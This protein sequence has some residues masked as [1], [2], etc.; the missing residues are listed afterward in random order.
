MTNPDGPRSNRGELAKALDDLVHD[1][2]RLA[3]A[4][5]MCEAWETGY[6]AR[7]L[8]DAEHIALH[9]SCDGSPALCADRAV[10]MAVEQAAPRRRV[11]R[12]GIT[13]TP[14]A[15]Q[16]LLDLVERRARFHEESWPLDRR[17]QPRTPPPVL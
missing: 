4:L 15:V 3:E 11:E 8:S 7:L 13:P 10:Q 17:A 1:D 12:A 6:V 5:A 16:A 9:Q 14:E 2:R